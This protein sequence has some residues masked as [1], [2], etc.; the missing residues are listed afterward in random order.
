MDAIKRF[1]VFAHK[2]KSSSL[3]EVTVA[4]V[5][6]SIAFGIFLMIHTNLLSG[7]SFQKL[8]YR[9]KLKSYYREMIRNRN[10]LDAVTE[11]DDVRVFRNVESYKNI[12]HLFFIE[13]KAVSS[14]G[15]MIARYRGLHYVQEAD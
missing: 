14:N 3:L 2:F 13:V 5:L 9:E 8:K 11:E 6:L 12:P 10:F 7:L 4:L 15:E 1:S